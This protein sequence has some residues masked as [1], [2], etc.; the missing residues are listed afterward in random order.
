MVFN[1]LHFLIFFSN[2]CTHTFYDADAYMEF[3]KEPEE[4]VDMPVISDFT[5]FFPGELF[6]NTKFVYIPVFVV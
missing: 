5:D 1:S 2:C 3:Q 4:K 6:L